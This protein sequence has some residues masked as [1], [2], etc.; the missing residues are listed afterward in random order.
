MAAI[1]LQNH[2]QDFLGYF[3][4]ATPECCP[5]GSGHCFPSTS[6]LREIFPE[7]YDAQIRLAVLFII[8][9]AN[10]DRSLTVMLLDQLKSLS[11]NKE[12]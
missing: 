5:S 6:T 8:F 3:Y 4:P 9:R 1:N 11:A 12:C 10:L 2:P 7:K